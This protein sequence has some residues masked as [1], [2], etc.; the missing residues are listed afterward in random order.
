MKRN[1]KKG[2]MKTAVGVTL[3]LSTLA[4]VATSIPLKS[5]AGTDDTIDW[6]DGSGEFK[7]I[8]EKVAKGKEPTWFYFNPKYNGGKGTPQSRFYAQP[9]GT[10]R[11]MYREVYPGGFVWYSIIPPEQ[12]RTSLAE[13]DLS[14]MLENR[15]TVVKGG[16]Y[17]VPRIDNKPYSENLKLGA[18]DPYSLS[19]K[20]NE[21]ADVPIL[22]GDF[23]GHKYEWRFRGYDITGTV[24]E[25][26]YFPADVGQKNFNGNTREETTRMR[27]DNNWIPYSWNLERSKELFGISKYNESEDKTKWVQD[28]FLKEYPQ[29]RDYGDAQHWADRLMPMTDPSK[30]TGVWVGW[31]K[32]SD[33]RIF[34][35]TFVTQAPKQP[36]LRIVEYAIYDDVGSKPGELDS[37][38]K[39]VAISTRGNAYDDWDETLQKKEK[40]VQKGKTYVI[41][42]KMRNM[43][44]KANDIKN[45]DITLDEMYAFDGTIGNPSAYTSLGESQQAQSPHQKNLKTGETAEFEYTYTVPTSAKPKDKILFGAQIPEKFYDLGANVNTNDDTS[46]ITMDVAPENLAVK[47]EGYYDINK[48]PVDYVTTGYD[49]F[50]KYRVTKTDGS[51]PVDGADLQIKLSDTLTTTNQTYDLEG[52]YDKNGRP[53]A[54][55]KLKKPGDYAI[56]WA[57]ITPRVPKLCTEASIKAGKRILG[58]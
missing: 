27:A 21:T 46:S 13:T 26:P 4:I 50:V 38:D 42:V 44:D 20:G 25:N 5:H 24:I 31:H 3:G 23:K 29:F 30:V 56:F 35:Q 8:K 57:T 41:K 33:G 22:Y 19:Y 12:K 6:G 54:D 17:I 34:Y 40:Y 37:G 14:F 52:A 1:K 51:L 16:D 55:G 53:I 2:R 43:P 39:L 28:Y 9:D 47:F 7:T 18:I 10:Q 36:N 48:N 49:M 32:V 58:V 45:T 11:L 15:Q